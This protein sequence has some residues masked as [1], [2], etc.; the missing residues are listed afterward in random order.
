MKL[1]KMTMAQQISFG[2]EGNTTK[3]S[4]HKDPV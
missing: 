4:T 1:E 3:I 2:F